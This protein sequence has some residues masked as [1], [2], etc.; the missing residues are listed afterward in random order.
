[1]C[2]IFDDATSDGTLR[3][4]S[5]ILWVKAQMKKEMARKSRNK[6]IMKMVEGILTS[7]Q[8]VGLLSD[9]WNVSLWMML[10]CLLQVVM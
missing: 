2:N 8:N 4:A 3:R 5:L 1:M 7:H 6:V 9:V 10:G